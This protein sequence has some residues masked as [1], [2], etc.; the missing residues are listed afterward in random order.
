MLGES[1]ERRGTEELISRYER[2]IAC[3]RQP[4]LRDIQRRIL[5]QRTDAVV[6]ER[7]RVSAALRD[8]GFTLPP[9]QANFVWLPLAERTLNFVA[10]AADNRIIV[11]PYGEDG[12]R[13]TIGA[14]H[15]N[16]AFLEFAQRWI[17]GDAGTRTGET[18]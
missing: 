6:A 4:G 3:A 10:R 15:E 12:V 14:P 11:R 18:K 7:T 16:D 1:P 17:E 2:Y 8:A 9:S 5:Q 13:V